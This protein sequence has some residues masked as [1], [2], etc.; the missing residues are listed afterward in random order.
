MKHES[1]VG[2]RGERTLEERVHEYPE[3]RGHLEALLEIVENAEGTVVKAD[4]AEERVI[5]ELRPLGRSAVQS[6]AE[7]KQRRLEREYEGRAGITRKVKKTSIG[8]RGLG[9]IELGEQIYRQ[10]KQQ[11]RP[12]SETAGVSCRGYSLGLQ[13]ALSDFGADV[14]F[15]KVPQKLKEHYGIEVP[16]SAAQTITERHAAAMKTQP[17]V[18][19]RLPRGGVAQ[20]VGELDGSMV[21]IVSIAVTGDQSTPRD[22]RKR[23]QLSWREA[24]LCLARVPDKVSGRYA[25]TLGGPAAAGAMF[26]DCV[27]RAG[28]GRATKLHCVGDGAKVSRQTI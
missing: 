9:Q 2:V 23:R 11:V 26:V 16:V 25:A 5:Q 7:R 10:G 24:R 12:F 6:W 22:D 20:L 8:T 27:I 15:G 18:L 17:A 28:G 19:Q 14:A 4:D 3:L 1:G 13:R 21:P